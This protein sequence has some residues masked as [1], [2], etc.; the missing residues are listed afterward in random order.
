MTKKRFFN[1]ELFV[2]KSSTGQISLFSL[3]IPILFEMIMNALQGT[4]NT[5][6]LSGY[7]D[8]AVAAVGAVNPVIS[9]LLLIT[10]VISQGITVV[11]SNHL[12]A[13][14]VKRAEEVSFSSLFTSTGI[15]LL[16]YLPL[17]LLA[18]SLMGMLNLTGE[19][20]EYAL[21]YFNYRV[22]F[23]VTQAITSV[24]YSI[25][26]CYGKSRYNF[27]IG[28]FVNVINLL[29]N[30]FVIYLPQ[31]SP[32]H[33]VE[34]VALSAGI[35]NL[36]G[37]LIVL[38]VIWRLK[39]RF[40]VPPSLRAFFENVG[41]ILKIGLPAAIS[42][43]SITIAQV[44]TTSFVALIGDWAL[45]A[46]VYYAGILNYAYFFSGAFGSANAIL[47]G[48]RFGA[49]EHNIADEM[50]R[51]L[52]RL[53][54]PINLIVSLTILLLSRPLVR[55]FTGDE[56]TL[57]LATLV[58]LV[59][60]VAEQARAIS[61]VYE[62]ALRGVGDVWFSLICTT[63]SCWVVNIGLAY[64]LSITCGLGLIGCFI[65][66][67]LDETVRAIVTVFRWKKG[68]WKNRTFV[69]M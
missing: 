1:R 28:L 9:M 47:V 14:N 20:Y 55:L 8:N 6:V 24:G 51:N 16:M 56:Q 52:I 31:Y 27:L 57:A 17:Y 19:I 30:I 42:S 60:I 59:D 10:S 35:S 61:Q 49:G 34:G 3:A 53:T 2:L 69:S 48:R 15:T 44:V 4:V 67:S 26:N 7:S 39:I 29:L 40:S 62:Y 25:L 64:F 45:S 12:G 66:I 43:A 65:A 13:E 22:A 36:I 63:V 37:M 58:F 33:G 5:A 50:N 46:K 54:I 38:L 23:M 21:I 32:V 18:P 68:K 41:A 11:V